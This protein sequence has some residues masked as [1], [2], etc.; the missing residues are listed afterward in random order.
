MI[1]TVYIAKALICFS[2]QCFPV[3][4]G[5]DTPIG[6]F[7]TQERRVISQGYEGSVLQ[8]YETENMVY[9]IHRPYSLDRRV[10]RKEVLRTGSSAQRRSISKGCINVE[11]E[12]FDELIEQ[13][14]NTLVIKH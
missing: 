2:G 3:L 9:A 14:Y 10:D 4:L 5:P 1:L 11:D 8:F 6:T 12:V 13:K 7:E